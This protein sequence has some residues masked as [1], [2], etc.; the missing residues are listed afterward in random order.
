MSEEKYAAQVAAELASISDEEPPAAG[1]GPKGASGGGVPPQLQPSPGLP[2]RRAAARRQQRVL[3]MLHTLPGPA[4]QAIRES[5]PDH[6]ANDP[7]RTQADP[8][9]AAQPVGAEREVGGG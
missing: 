6:P 1:T 8:R 7:G 4:Q 2:E 9:P 5:L 3:D